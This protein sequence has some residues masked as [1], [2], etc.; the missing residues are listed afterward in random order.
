LTPSSSPLSLRTSLEQIST[1]L[2]R[3][4]MASEAVATARDALRNHRNPPILS[5]DDQPD[6]PPALTDAEMTKNMACQVCYSQIADIAVLPCG[7]MVMCQWCADVVCP[8]KHASVPVRTTQCPM[9]RK[10]V[11]SRVRIHTG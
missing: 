4:R 6:R 1:E 7:H 2:S 3:L 11:K 10:A 9:C 5:L 8:V